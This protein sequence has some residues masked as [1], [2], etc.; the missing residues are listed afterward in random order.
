MSFWDALGYVFIGKTVVEAIKRAEPG[1]P[2]PIPEIRGIK[3]GK[4]RFTL[5]GATAVPEGE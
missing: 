1:E 5:T 2:V 4:K 3:V